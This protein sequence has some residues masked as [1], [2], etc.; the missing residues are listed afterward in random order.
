[1]P[2]LAILFTC[3]CVHGQVGGGG[4]FKP[5]KAKGVDY[6]HKGEQI[7]I[8][9]RWDYRGGHVGLWSSLGIPPNC[10]VLFL[11]NEGGGSCHMRGCHTQGLEI[12]LRKL[13]VLTLNFHQ[14]F[15]WVIIIIINF[16]FFF[17]FTPMFSP[18]T[19]MNIYIYI[20][21]FFYINHIA[22]CMCNSLKCYAP[23][24]LV[25]LEIGIVVHHPISM[26]SLWFEVR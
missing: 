26:A 15:N 3:A 2:N 11:G 24:S 10:V 16:F 4:W 13:V 8:R 23:S 17:F 6:G 25:S 7:Y 1:M 5:T 21:R 14:I 12:D 18:K 19:N 22:I 20:D 9:T